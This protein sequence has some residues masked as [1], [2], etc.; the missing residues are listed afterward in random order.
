MLGSI[1][2]DGSDDEGIAREYLSRGAKGLYQCH[3]PY[4]AK[5]GMPFRTAYKIVGQLVAECIEKNTVLD[6]LPLQEYQK[7]SDLFAED[8]YKEIALET[9]VEKRNSFGGASPKSVREQ[10][11]W[12]KAQL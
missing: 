5:K 11:A 3:R 8:L 7:Y 6:D 9:C 1:R 2:A 4:L 10:I 12:V